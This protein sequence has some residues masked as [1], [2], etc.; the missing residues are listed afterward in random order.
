VQGWSH[1]EWLCLQ[2]MRNY[3]KGCNQLEWARLDFSKDR[4]GDF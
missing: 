1:L 4:T 3:R 2:C